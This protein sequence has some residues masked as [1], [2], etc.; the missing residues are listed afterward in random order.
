V[1]SALAG[2][3]VISTI[4][5]DTSSRV[6]V[7]MP[8]TLTRLGRLQQGDTTIEMRLRVLAVTLGPTPLADLEAVLV[9]LDHLPRTEAE[10]EEPPFELWSALAVA[11]RPA[12]IIR[13]EVPVTL[14]APPVPTVLAPMRV[15]TRVVGIIEGIL[16]GPGNVALPFGTVTAAE[17][18]R[19]VSADRNGR[20]RLAVPVDDDHLA[21]IVEVKGRT[22]TADIPLPQAGPILVHCDGEE[23]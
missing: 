22:F 12:A 15:D 4:P 20:F 18:D 1:Q 17:Y 6:V 8:L 13:L 16:V 14:A 2:V 10:R 21:L 11:P 23:S 5:A 3:S 19:A 7:L 9:A